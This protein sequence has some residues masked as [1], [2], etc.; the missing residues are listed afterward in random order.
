MKHSPTSFN[1]QSGRIVIVTGSKNKEL[2]Q[3]VEKTYLALLGDDRKSITH[4]PSSP[5]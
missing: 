3:L 1:M 2:W 5:P 4:F